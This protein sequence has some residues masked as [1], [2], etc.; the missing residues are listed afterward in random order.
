MNN[1]KLVA[2]SFAM[3]VALVVIISP[4]TA[5]EAGIN[6][7]V[8]FVEWMGMVFPPH[9]SLTDYPG[10]KEG[11]QFDPSTLGL[12][13]VTAERS[14]S[15]LNQDRKTGKVFGDI[16]HRGEKY[17]AREDDA[18]QVP[19]YKS[20]CLN[21]VFAFVGAPTDNQLLGA[22]QALQQQVGALQTQVGQLAGGVAGIPAAT[23]QELQQIFPNL[24]SGPSWWPLIGVLIGLATLGLLIWC[25]FFKN[26]RKRKKKPEP[27][28]DPEPMPPSGGGEAPSEPSLGDEPEEPG[29]DDGSD[30]EPLTDPE[31]EPTTPVA[32]PE[33]MDPD[34]PP[35]APK[36]EA[37]PRTEKPKEVPAAEPRRKPT[38]PP[39]T[40]E[41]RVTMRRPT[42]GDKMK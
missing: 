34:G 23:A 32:P 1:R 39:M 41:E 26:K 30:E 10:Y 5:Q 14:W 28:D 17:W 36:P 37:K 2:V 35:K 7:D 20:D 33:L 42:N 19:I 21:R 11:V 4:V 24:G 18:R 3:V 38:P 27:S 31:P 13:E 6:A 22:I 16:L 40:L 8:R 15:I 25:C 9:S 29:K 12:V